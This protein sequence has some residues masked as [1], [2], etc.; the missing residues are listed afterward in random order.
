[1][2]L[3][4]VSL[5]RPPYVHVTALHVTALRHRRLHLGGNIVARG[6]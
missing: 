3:H 6:A 4:V 2:F 1:M 5:A